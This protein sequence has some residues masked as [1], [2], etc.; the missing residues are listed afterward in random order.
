MHTKCDSLRKLVI[1]EMEKKRNGEKISQVEVAKKFNIHPNTV[2]KYVR[3]SKALEAGIPYVGRCVDELNLPGLYL[4][5]L[6]LN[7]ESLQTA[8]GGQSSIGGKRAS[9]LPDDSFH[10][11]DG[12]RW[13]TYNGLWFLDDAA[14]DDKKTLLRVAAGESYRG[15]SEKD[16]DE[17]VKRMGVD[18]LYVLTTPQLSVTGADLLEILNARDTLG[19]RRAVASTPGARL[20]HDEAWWVTKGQHWVQDDDKSG[21]KEIILQV[22]MGLMPVPQAKKGGG[23]VASTMKLSKQHKIFFTQVLHATTLSLLNAAEYIRVHVDS[24]FPV[25]S[26]TTLYNVAKAMGFT[27]KRSSV[28]DPKKVATLAKEL[29]EKAFHHELHSEKGVLRGENLLFMDESNFYL[30]MDEDPAPT[31]GKPGKNASNVPMSKGKSQYLS[32]IL[33]VGLVFNPGDGDSSD[34]KPQWIQEWQTLKNSTRRPISGDIRDNPTAIGGWSLVDGTSANLDTHLLLFWHIVPPMRKPHLGVFYEFDEPFSEEEETYWRT[35]RTTIIAQGQNVEDFITNMTIA[36]PGNKKL[37]ENTLFYLG[38]DAR[39]IVDNSVDTHRI[40]TDSELKHRFTRLVVHKSRQGLPRRFVGPKY[41]GGSPQPELSTTSKF[42]HYLKTLSSYT[43]ACFGDKVVGDARVFLDNAPTH[44]RVNVDSNAASFLH[45]YAKTLDFEGA[46]FPPSLS[47]KY[48]VAEVVFAYIKTLIRNAGMP[49]SG[50]HSVASMTDTIETALMQITP[51]MVAAWTLSRG[52][53]FDGAIASDQLPLGLFTQPIPRSTGGVVFGTHKYTSKLRA[54]GE[55]DPRALRLAYA[56]PDGSHHAE[57]TTAIVDQELQKLDKLAHEVASMRFH[58][59]DALGTASDTVLNTVARK[60]SKR[61]QSSL[62]DFIEQL[63]LYTATYAQ[64]ATLMGKMTPAGDAEEQP[65]L[66]KH[67]YST[68]PTIPMLTWAQL[69]DALLVLAEVVKYHSKAIKRSK[70]SSRQLCALGVQDACERERDSTASVCART[71]PS[72]HNDIICMNEMGQIANSGRVAQS[73]RES[74]KRFGVNM[75]HMQEV[76]NKTARLIGTKGI[77]LIAADIYKLAPASNSY[78]LR[79]FAERVVD[80][81]VKGSLRPPRAPCAKT[82]MGEEEHTFIIIRDWNEWVPIGATDLEHTDIPITYLKE[83]NYPEYEL[84]EI[85]V[86]EF[87]DNNQWGHMI[88]KITPKNGAATSLVYTHVGFSPTERL[89]QI[90]LSSMETKDLTRLGADVIEVSKHD[91]NASYHLQTRA[92][93]PLWIVEHLKNKLNAAAADPSLLQRS[94]ESNGLYSQIWNHY[95]EKA[96]VADLSLRDN[97]SPS[98]EGDCSVAV[99]PRCSNFRRL[100]RLMLDMQFP[101]SIVKAAHFYHDVTKSG[102]VPMFSAEKIRNRARWEKEHEEDRAGRLDANGPQRRWPGYPMIT[103][104]HGLQSVRDAHWITDNR[105]LIQRY[106][107]KYKDGGGIDKEALHVLKPFTKYTGV[108]FLQLPDYKEFCG[109][110]AMPDTLLGAFGEPHDKF[111]DIRKLILRNKTPIKNW[112]DTNVKLWNE[113]L[114]KKVSSELPE[115]LV[116]VFPAMLFLTVGEYR[117]YKTDPDKLDAIRQLFLW[118]N[119][120]HTSHT[121]YSLRKIQR[122]IE[123]SMTSDTKDDEWIVYLPSHLEQKSSGKVWFA[124]IQANGITLNTTISTIESKLRVGMPWDFVRSTDMRPVKDMFEGVKRVY[125]IDEFS[126]IDVRAAIDALKKLYYAQ[127]TEYMTSVSKSSQDEEFLKHAETIIEK[128]ASDAIKKVNSG[129]LRSEN[130]SKTFIDNFQTELRKKIKFMEQYNDLTFW[131]TVGD[132]S[133]YYVIETVPDDAQLGDDKK[134]DIQN[135]SD[136]EDTWVKALVNICQQRNNQRRNRSA[137][138]PK[139]VDAAAPQVVKTTVSLEATQPHLWLI[140]E[141]T[142][143]GREQLDAF[144][145]VTK[146]CNTKLSDTFKLYRREGAENATRRGSFR[147]VS[148]TLTFQQVL[149]ALPEPWFKSPDKSIRAYGASKYASLELAVKGISAFESEPSFVPKNVC[150]LHSGK[151]WMPEGVTKATGHVR[152]PLIRIRQSGAYFQLMFCIE[153]DSD[154]ENPQTKWYMTVEEIK[155]LGFPVVEVKS[156]YNKL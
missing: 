54:T 72:R 64:L 25:V 155:K 126:A 151:I 142:G 6:S 121:E 133:D 58:Y 30:N 123:S 46:V 125:G 36:T 85:S 84:Q 111:A 8:L 104:S 23:L 136:I 148:D 108:V 67:A 29:E 56:A 119:I 87:D 105:T 129:V 153:S 7:S 96:R 74:H 47:P 41:K 128:A 20:F 65:S 33:T 135:I 140:A 28:F 132:M 143:G 77:K 109:N 4:I 138:V 45:A 154:G 55:V 50:Q 61:V 82:L 112:T 139:R 127:A 76:F 86:N 141:R 116:L 14:L 62:G 89:R 42:M 106:I 18:P 94:D 21:A 103:Y 38:V 15:V 113:L 10:E 35:V 22:G 124:T 59:Q 68:L 11:Y 1:R 53:R 131:P 3:Q 115:Q 101:A 147:R 156:T 13:I 37:V 83:Y 117:R 152:S 81:V 60:L 134:Y 114:H 44:G 75:G 49:P 52:Y 16:L 70:G 73:S 66:D 32:L 122:S 39:A 57:D 100:R 91:R 78:P 88:V 19:G 2:G 118:K 110:S 145:L 31:W 48:N 92:H 90:A 150:L 71:F 51:A 149:E 27:K 12:Q 9:R 146:H 43:K 144:S 34:I 130:G 102:Q 137:R 5:R 95:C 79:P 99:T 26:E 69:D 120:T 93:L 98:D 40:A 63:P 24:T 97:I 107:R 17:C 80:F